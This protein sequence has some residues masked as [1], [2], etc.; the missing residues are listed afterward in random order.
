MSQS[1]DN[2]ISQTSE[3]DSSDSI[4]SNDVSSVQLTNE[5]STPSTSPDVILPAWFRFLKSWWITCILILLFVTAYILFFYA[6][7]GQVVIIENGPQSSLYPTYDKGDLFFIFKPSPEEIKLGDIIVYRNNHD[8]TLIIHRVVDIMVADGGYFFRVSGDN[9]VTNVNTDVYDSPSGETWIPYSSVVGRT[10][11]LIPK[12]GYLSIWFDNVG[13]RLPFGRVTL[14]ATLFIILTGIILFWPTE[15]SE[16]DNNT[17]SN[18]KG[19][20]QPTGKE[21]LNSSSNNQHAFSLKEEIKKDYNKKKDQLQRIMTVDS[22]RNGIKD[23]RVLGSL[24]IAFLLLISVPALDS[25]N[26]NGNENAL[27]TPRLASSPYGSVDINNPPTDVAIYGIFGF[28]QDGS[29]RNAIREITLTLQQDGNNLSTFVWNALGVVEGNA[30]FSFTF[31]V[32]IEEVNFGQS[33]VIIAQS[34]VDVRFGSDQPLMTTTPIE[35]PAR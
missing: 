26:F 20:E 19:Q 25:V 35:L 23:Y 34:K 30:T 6:F 11:A 14:F 32:L 2:N 21:S 10:E 5:D 22:M 3:E 28:T 7:D 27:T 12:V 33:A 15:E 29:W 4:S 24:A 13:S 17:S 18:Q 1:S 8:S 9:A 16:K 31:I